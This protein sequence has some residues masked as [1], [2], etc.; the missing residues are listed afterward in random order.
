MRVVIWG[1]RGSVA[2]PGPDTVRCG[3]NTSCMEISLDDGTVFMLDAGTG[4][5]ELGHELVE[6]GVRQRQPPAH[7]PASRPPRGASVLRPALRPRRRRST[8]GARARPVLDAEGADQALVLAAALPDRP[9]GHARRGCLPRA[10]EDAVEDRGRAA[11][12]EPHRP[13][14]AHRRLPDRGGRIERRV[15]PRPRA[16]SG[17]RLHASDRATGSRAA[18]SPR[19]SIYCS[20]TR[21]TSTEEYDGRLGWGHSSVEE[22]G[23]VRGRGR[24]RGGSSCST[25]TRPIRTTS[26]SASRSRRRSIGSKTRIRPVSRAKAWCSSSE[27]RVGPRLDREHTARP[28]PPVRAGERSRALAEARVPEPDRVDEGPD[29]ARDGRGRGARR[30][31]LAG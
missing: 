9:H 30:A 24:A 27:R 25:T 7:A 2:T 21:S 28:P 15:H 1:C 18:R 5:R 26:W 31:D 20:T 3:G 6:R 23:C 11:H 4:I 29:G 19:T 10:A 13:S 12:R 8:S 14:R 22:R 17:R 16:G